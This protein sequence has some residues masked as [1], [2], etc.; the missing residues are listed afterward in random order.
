MLNSGNR[1]PAKRDFD[2]KL[3]GVDQSFRSSYSQD[4]ETNFVVN[5]RS[6]RP[7]SA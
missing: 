6:Q 3:L 1:K 5:E 2:E 7:R 4:Q